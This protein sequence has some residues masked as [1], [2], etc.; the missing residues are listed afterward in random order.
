M[1]SGYLRS[2]GVGRLHVAAS[3]PVAVLPVAPGITTWCDGHTLTW[4][5]AREQVTWPLA[6]EEDA[7]RQLADLTGNTGA[8]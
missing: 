5:H 6:D 1:L 7:A 3:P 8:W 4:R 2:P